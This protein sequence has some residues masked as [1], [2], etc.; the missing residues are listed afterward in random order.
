MTQLPEELFDLL[1]ILCEGSMT[2]Q[3]AARLEELVD[4]SLDARQHYIRYLQMQAMVERYHVAPSDQASLARSIGAFDQ[5]PAGRL[6]LT[7]KCRGVAIQH[8][9]HSLA[10]GRGCSNCETNQRGIGEKQ[11]PFRR[12]LSNAFARS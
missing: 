12:P 6:F 9:K 3:Q 10:V 7:G 2:P 4:Q 11:E 8:R 5:R 1:D